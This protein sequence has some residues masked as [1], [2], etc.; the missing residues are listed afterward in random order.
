MT[1]L[2]TLSLVLLVLLALLVAGASATEPM[3]LHL[4]WTN[5]LH[6]HI[7]P[8]EARFMNPEFPPPLGGAAS[9]ATYIKRVRAQAEAA[10][11]HVLLVDVGD[12]FQGTP[13][14]TK[15]EGKAVIDYFN[16]IGYDLLVPG[17][18]D[19]DLGRDVAETLAEQSSFPW[20]ACNL[21]ETATGEVVDWCVPELMLEFGGVKIGVVGIITPGTKHMSFPENIKGLDFLPMAAAIEQSR[22]RLLAQGA[23]LIMLGIHEGLPYD[24]KQGW[25]NIAGA[26]Q[27]DAEDEHGHSHGANY[28][29]TGVPNL[30]E[31]MNQVSGVDFAVG[32][33]T[34]RGY[35]EPWIDPVNHTLCFES[36]GNG[37]S[38]GHAI[39]LVDPES[40]QLVGWERSHDRGTL[41]TLFEDEIEPDP[42]IT[43]VLRPYVE[44]TARAMARQVGTAAVNLS[45]GGP[46]NSLMGNLVTDAMRTRFEADFS[47]QNMGGLRADLP[48]GPITAGDIFGVLPFGNELVI[49]EI[50]GRMLRRIVER[51]LRGESGGICISGAEVTYDKGRPDWDRVV[52]LTVGGEPWDPDRTYKAVCTN[53][54]LEGNS[55]LG[56]LTGIEADKVM[57]TQVR[58]SEAVEWYFEQHDPVRPRIDSRWVEKPGQGQAPYLASEYLP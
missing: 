30:M 12:I 1:T 40:K 23:D 29:G 18:H 20:V 27:T 6:G 39:L 45:R 5:D 4:I 9:A 2:R 51:K 28:S 22:D 43:E 11:E 47:F 54:L 33:H 16:A 26:E 52:S 17:N 56:F 3:R 24:P 34:H 35:H 42:E 50:D 57:P 44:E 13:I 55:G 38:I 53:F 46:G 8:E 7:A 31:L 37:S 49:I 14:G 32:G 19:F 15:T 21:V 41:I 58:T 36:Y 10:G 48:Q 25:A